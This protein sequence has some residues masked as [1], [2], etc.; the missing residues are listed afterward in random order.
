MGPSPPTAVDLAQASPLFPSWPVD[1]HMQLEGGAAHALINCALRARRCSRR[2]SFQVGSRVETLVMS[3]RHSREPQSKAQ[4]RGACNNSLST[5]CGQREAPRNEK[6]LPLSAGLEKQRKN[7]KEKKR[8]GEKGEESEKLRSERGKARRE[9]QR[10][11]KGQ[12]K[13]KQRQGT[14]RKESKVRKSEVRQGKRN[15]LHEL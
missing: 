14:R 7:R 12:G 10:Q 5:G 4:R 2:G 15:H 13:A 3:Q 6:K 9:R 1:C 11:K 8:R